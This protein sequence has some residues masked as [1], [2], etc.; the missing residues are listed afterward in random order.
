M[1]SS[2]L[3]FCEPAAVCSAA[4]RSI[5]RLHAL[6]RNRLFSNVCPEPAL[7]KDRFYPNG[8]KTPFSHRTRTEQWCICICLCS[9]GLV[10]DAAAQ[11]GARSSLNTA[12]EDESTIRLRAA[13]R[14]RSI[15]QR[16]M[17]LCKATD[18][19]QAAN[20]RGGRIVGGVSLALEGA[21]RQRLAARDCGQTD[22]IIS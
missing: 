16:H 22:T 11:R 2:Q 14:R 4:G 6:L 8:A 9:E 20:S 18:C 12:L 13:N 3:L 15:R 17:R 1:C 21:R 7:A 19:A 10:T 5:N